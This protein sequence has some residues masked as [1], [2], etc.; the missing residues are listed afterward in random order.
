MDNDKKNYQ[1]AELQYNIK[2]TEKHIKMI[3]NKKERCNNYLYMINKLT[4][5][6]QII[7]N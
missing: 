3:E 4:A 7:M 1:I 6:Q 5:K 2:K